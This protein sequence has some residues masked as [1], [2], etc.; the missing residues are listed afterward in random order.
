G[1]H[2]LLA[3]VHALGD[4]EIIGASKDEAAGEA[5]DKTAKTLGLDY[6]AGP[7]LARLA[8]Q[9]QP[10]H[11]NFTRPM[12]ARPGLDFSFSGLKTAVVVAV[13]GVELD[14][15]ARADV[16]YEFQQAV[17]DTL[18]AKC[19][20]ALVQT[21]LSTLVVAGGVG[22]NECLRAALRAMGERRG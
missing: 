7:A 13:R 19:Q 8:G 5:L 3:E 1:G 20:R 15:Q 17:V 6:L 4:Y 9:G 16:A 10:G 12:L 14:E 22:A 11:Y 2:T 21:G 18:I